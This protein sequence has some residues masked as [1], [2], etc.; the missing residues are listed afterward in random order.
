MNLFTTIQW[1][2]LLT[3]DQGIKPKTIYTRWMV[4]KNERRFEEA[5][6]A[7]NEMNGSSV[8]DDHYC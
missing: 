4:P 8:V 5:K 7:N 6:V 3:F 2:T 1:V